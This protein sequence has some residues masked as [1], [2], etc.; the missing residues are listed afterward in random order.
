MQMHAEIWNDPAHT[1]ARR[2]NISEKGKNRKDLWDRKWAWHVQGRERQPVLWSKERYAKLEGRTWAEKKMNMWGWRDVQRLRSFRTLRKQI[3]LLPLLCAHW[4]VQC[5]F[6]TKAA[7]NP[8]LYSQSCFH[9]LETL[10]FPSHLITKSAACSYCKIWKI[11]QHRFNH[12]GWF[13]LQPN[14]QSCT[15]MGWAVLL[16][17]EV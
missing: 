3:F 5:L 17:N 4:A 7:G 10:Y 6:F 11:L 16:S 8:G 15:I 1:K 12:H 2:K 13:F 14:H 9:F